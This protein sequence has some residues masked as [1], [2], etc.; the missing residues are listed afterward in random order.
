MPL[1]FILI[2][3]TLYWVFVLCI[4]LSIAGSNIAFGASFKAEFRKWFFNRVIWNLLVVVICIIVA[5]NY[6]NNPY[7][8]ENSFKNIVTY[9][10]MAFL[11][12]AILSRFF[13]G[14]L[15]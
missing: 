14:R 9:N 10:H 6:F 5:F 13:H 15:R 7:T 4:C 8:S 1:A 12:G 11:L 2:S 3:A